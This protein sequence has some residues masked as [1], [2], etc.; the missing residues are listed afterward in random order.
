MTQEEKIKICSTCKLRT[1]NIKEGVLCGRTGKKPEFDDAC[2]DYDADSKEIQWQKNKQEELEKSDRISGFMSFFVYWSIPLGIAWTII[3]L[4]TAPA[5]PPEFIGNVCLKMMGVAYYAVYFYFASYTIYA[6]INKKSDA[7]FTAKYIL[8][9]SFLSN[10]LGLITGETGGDILGDPT[11]IVISLLWGLIFFFYLVFSHNVKSWIPKEKRKLMKHN[12]VIFI[13]SLVLPVLLYIGAIFEATKDMYGFT[14]FS[15]DKV[16]IESLCKHTRSVLPRD[17]DE[18]LIWTDVTFDGQVV[19]YKYEYSDA[20]YRDNE[21]F[22]SEA[23]LKLITNYQT[24]SLK[25]QSVDMIISDADPIFKIISK[26]GKYDI[27]YSYY[28]PDGDLLYC[29]N[30]PGE[31]VREIAETGAYTTGTES[32]KALVDSY[33]AL[34]PVEYIGGCM[35]QNC[36]LSEDATTLH[37]D[38]QLVNMTVGSLANLTQQSLKEYMMELIPYFSD[39]PGIIARVNGKNLSFDFTADCSDWWRCKVLIKVDEYNQLYAE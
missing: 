18:Q 15:S 38:L 19:E 24:E 16:K 33:N 31:E 27:R 2:G 11:R 35:L 36:S 39:A 25:L 28:S 9:I 3:G 12:K 34:M 7:V 8:I 26:K 22:E 37:Y 23:T 5:L 21:E 4:F 17:V 1:F 20:V 13:L 14:L 6:F 32:F 10:L 30:M 29:V